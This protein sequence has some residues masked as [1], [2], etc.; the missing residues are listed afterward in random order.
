LIDLDCNEW[1]QPSIINI[2]PNVA[3]GYN[4]ISLCF[5]SCLEKGFSG[6]INN[7]EYGCVNFLGNSKFINAD[8]KINDCTPIYDFCIIKKSKYEF[9][10]IYNRKYI[11]DICNAL[12]VN[13][14]DNINICFNLSKNASIRD[15]NN[16]NFS[17]CNLFLPTI[18]DFDYSYNFE[19]NKSNYIQNKELTG[20]W[21][22]DPNCLNI[23][24]GFINSSFITSCDSNEY[25]NNQ[26]FLKTINLFFDENRSCSPSTCSINSDSYEIIKCTTASTFTYDCINFEYTATDY[27]LY[28]NKYY[29]I[30]NE[31][32]PFIFCT[33]D[34][35]EEVLFPINALNY[36]NLIINTNYE[37]FENLK[38]L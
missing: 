14:T 7:N 22:D 16:K 4:S 34:Y 5:T 20:Y 29:K 27:I 35:C 19:L 30:G 18:C 24:S 28:K 36:N 3:S 37:I 10:E 17:A 2:T 32:V 33:N 21:I 38:F 8:L 31:C 26:P 12:E 13:E 25:L 23:N 9:E 6:I 15:L 11:L 1:V